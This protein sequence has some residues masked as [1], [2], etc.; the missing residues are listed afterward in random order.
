VGSCIAAHRTGA[1]HSDS[2]CHSF[3]F[4]VCLTG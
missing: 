4:L 2:L 3:R 1:D